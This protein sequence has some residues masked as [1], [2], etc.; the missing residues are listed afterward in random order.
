MSAL[1]RAT[2]FGRKI[3]EGIETSSCNEGETLEAI[4]SFIC[5]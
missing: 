2:Q 5:V 4:P 3:P 1:P